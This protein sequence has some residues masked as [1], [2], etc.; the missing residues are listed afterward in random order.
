LRGTAAFLSL[1]S[2]NEDVLVNTS[3]AF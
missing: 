2:T 3:S 1:I